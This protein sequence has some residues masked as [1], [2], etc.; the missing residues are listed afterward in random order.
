MNELSLAL[1]LDQSVSIAFSLVYNIYF[2]RLC[3]A[4][5]EEVMSQQFHLY[6]RIF[7]EHWLHA[8]LLA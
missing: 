4:E 2:I 1:W 6:T 5:Y 7:R 3:V 8:K